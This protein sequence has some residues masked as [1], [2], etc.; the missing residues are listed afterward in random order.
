MDMI[1]KQVVLL[2]WKILVANANQSGVVAK[3]PTT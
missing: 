2:F 1:Q 3:T